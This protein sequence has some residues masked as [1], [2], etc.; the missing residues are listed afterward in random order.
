MVFELKWLLWSLKFDL[1][2]I[3]VIL[4]FYNLMKILS[5]N[6]LFEFFDTFQNV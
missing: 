4:K 6:L 3:I 1:R 5:D 2:P